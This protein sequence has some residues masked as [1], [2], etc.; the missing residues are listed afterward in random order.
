MTHSGVPYKSS[1]QN[2]FPIQ[3]EN[4]LTFHPHIHEAAVI[5]VPDDRLGETVG[6]WIVRSSH[7]ES[8]KLNRRDVKLWVTAEM[9]PQVGKLCC[10]AEIFKLL[11]IRMRLPMFGLWERVAFRVN[12]LKPQVVKYKSIYFA[13]GLGNSK[14]KV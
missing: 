13:I 14:Q 7:P 6:V 5:A 11:S 8:G 12:Y 10:K 3:I 4:R 2:L 9:N 1:L